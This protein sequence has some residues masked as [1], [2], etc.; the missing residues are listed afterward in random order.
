[1]MSFPVENA[2]I[3]LG[4]TDVFAFE[5]VRIVIGEGFGLTSCSVTE[6]PVWPCPAFTFA[7]T[8][9]FFQKAVRLPRDPYGSCFRTNYQNS[10]QTTDFSG[11]AGRDFSFP[12]CLGKAM[13]S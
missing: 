8:W 7:R 5:G 13:L 3:N 4:V 10:S 12:S 2:I 9:H 1:M 6:L 11:L